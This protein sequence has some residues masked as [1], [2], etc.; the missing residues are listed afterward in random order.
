MQTIHFNT[1][2]A[3]ST[4]LQRITATLHDD[5]VVTFYD[6]DRQIDGEFKLPGDDF[7]A[8][9]VMNAYLNNIAKGTKRSLED[10]YIVSCNGIYFGLEVAA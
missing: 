1:G 7:S 3:Y 10:G 5:R 6:H 2:A 4:A 8:A 9:V